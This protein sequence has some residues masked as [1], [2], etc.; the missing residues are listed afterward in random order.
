M[1]TGDLMIWGGAAI[2]LGGVIGLFACVVYV[3][4]VRRAGL[5]DAA[6]RKALQKGV[7]WNMSAL[8]VSVLGLMTV[9]IGIALS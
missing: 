6:L 9:I 8:F 5:E 1:S 2:T 7:L 4:R 3:L